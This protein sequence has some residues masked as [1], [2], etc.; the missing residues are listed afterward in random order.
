MAVVA[1][2]SSAGSAHGLEQGERGLLRHGAGRGC[3]RLLAGACGAE[4]RSPTAALCLVTPTGL[5]RDWI[6]RNAWRRVEELVGR[7]T[8]RTVASCSLKSRVEYEAEAGAGIG[9]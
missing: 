5:A 2:M 8:I 1:Q 4:A 9:A 3:V 7:P 6:R